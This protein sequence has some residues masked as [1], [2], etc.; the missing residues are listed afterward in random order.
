MKTMR[1]VVNK[2]FEYERAGLSR[3]EA[4]E[5]VKIERL[6]AINNRLKEIDEKINSVS[7]QLAKSDT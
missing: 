7:R 2:V 4:I 5:I 3:S 1:D 6:V